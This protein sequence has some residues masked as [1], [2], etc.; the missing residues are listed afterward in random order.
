M[1]PG[2]AKVKLL[3]PDPKN[4]PVLIFY[5]DVVRILH[6]DLNFN[7]YID[8]PESEDPAELALAQVFEPWDLDDTEAMEQPGQSTSK[9]CHKQ[10]RHS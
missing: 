7:Y 1:A 2:Y 8:N 4:F 6:L 9:V 5:V 10:D 3:D